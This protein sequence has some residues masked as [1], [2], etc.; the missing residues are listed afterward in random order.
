MSNTGDQHPKFDIHVYVSVP[1]AELALF[2]NL[3][4]DWVDLILNQ[5]LRRWP[6]IKTTLGQRLSA[7][8]REVSPISATS[9]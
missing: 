7:G 3:Y 6:N 8:G 1:Y 2:V 5:R 4:I 9:R